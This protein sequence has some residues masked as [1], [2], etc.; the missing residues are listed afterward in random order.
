MINDYRQ[1]IYCDKLNEISRRAKQKIENN[2]STSST[3]L[4]RMRVVDVN[5]IDRTG[6]LTIWNLNESINEIKENTAIEL[7]HF[8][9]NGNRGK[10]ILLST[11]NRT[12][13]QTISQREFTDLHELSKRKCVELESITNIE[14]KPIFN[15]IDCVVYIL[16]TEVKSIETRF[17]SVYAVDDRKNI[18]KIKFWN[19]ISDYG[20]DDVVQEGRFIAI[21]NLD[22]RSTNAR[23]HDGIVQVFVTE[24]TTFSEMP[25]SEEMINAMNGLKDRFNEIENLDEYLE[26]C[27]MITNQNK[28]IPFVSSKTNSCGNR[29]TTSAINSFGMTKQQT[30]TQIKMDKLKNVG[31]APPPPAFAFNRNTSIA[32]SKPFKSPM[33][34]VAV[35]KDN[36]HHNRENNY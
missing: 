32:L 15:E 10:D 7:T 5:S 31:E 34:T 9:T 18:L 23:R 33:A 24:I 35:A 28:N 21:H 2:Q 25:K 29:A 20:Y 8:A 22:W 4:L 26:E 3:P 16:S 6:I 36:N 19:K 11:N 13:I 14:F 17:Q 30:L 12:T 1:K 27:L